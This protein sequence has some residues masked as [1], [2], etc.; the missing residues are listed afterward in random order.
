M[1][2]WLQSVG[3]PICPSSCASKQLGYITVKSGSKISNLEA[4]GPQPLSLGLSASPFDIGSPR[5][6]GQLLARSMAAYPNESFRKEGCHLLPKKVG[7]LL[8]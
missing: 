4:P 5:H 1:C 6:S 7:F 3:I 2:R 8:S